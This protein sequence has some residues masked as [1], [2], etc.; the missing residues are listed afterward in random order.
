MKYLATAVATLM[1]PLAH[2]YIP[3]SGFQVEQL[4]KQKNVLQSLS[5]DS[6][7]ILYRDGQPTDTKFF[8]RTLVDFKERKI[9]SV[10]ML[11]ASKRIYEIQRKVKLT[12]SLAAP[13]FELLLDRDASSLKVTLLNLGIPIRSEFELDRAKSEEERR[14]MEKTN[15]KRW[16]D[17]QSWV[18]G[19]GASQFWLEKSSFLPLRLLWKDGKGVRWEAEFGMPYLYR[20]NLSYPPTIWIRRED[21][22]VM[23]IRTQT[24]DAD[25][26]GLKFLP[27]SL[28]GFT[29]EGQSV[30][31]DLRKGLGL[32]YR[33]VR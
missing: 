15:L 4:A 29:H 17:R 10:A 32:Y 6:L 3:R 20:D 23:E 12:S 1:I 5:I 13:L 9:Q 7:V 26:K 33:W 8:E 21:Q 19:E 24:V 2:A 27:K 16:K 22:L 11:D 25:V 18:I 31:E 30:D 14:S 28:N